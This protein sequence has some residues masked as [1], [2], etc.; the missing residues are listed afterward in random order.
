MSMNSIIE[1]LKNG[2]IG[3]RIS[4]YTDKLHAPIDP[5][6]APGNLSEDYLGTYRVSDIKE[7]S[8]RASEESDDE[9][10]DPDIFYT[11]LAL[12][13]DGFLAIPLRTRRCVRTGS[14]V[15][16]GDE[17]LRMCPECQE[18]VDSGGVKA[19]ANDNSELDWLKEVAS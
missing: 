6:T 1:K 5:L 15:N 16:N 13:P 9:Y 14:I 10:T 3:V 17:H 2:V 7:R 18:E 12:L 4:S 19:G 8:G 11:R